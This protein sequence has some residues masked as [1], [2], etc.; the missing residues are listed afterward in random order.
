MEELIDVLRAISSDLAEMK[1]LLKSAGLT[2]K[3]RATLNAMQDKLLSGVEAARMLGCSPQ[4]VGHMRRDG[5]IKAKIVGK[6]WRYP[7][8]EVLRP[9]YNVTVALRTAHPRWR[10]ESSC[11]TKKEATPLSGPSEA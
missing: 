5:R 7:Q 3:D 9:G 10:F 1:Q 2:D 8:S 11:P 6:C 4:T